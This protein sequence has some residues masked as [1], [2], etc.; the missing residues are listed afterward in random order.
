MQEEKGS[1]EG[2]M[3]MNLSKLW[4]LVMTEKPGIT[5]VYGIAKS[6]T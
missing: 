6:W 3:D 2:E 1:T 4:E 5:A